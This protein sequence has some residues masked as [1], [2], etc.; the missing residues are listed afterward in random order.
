LPSLVVCRLL[1]GAT[2]LRESARTECSRPKMPAH[3]MVEAEALRGRAEMAEWR[4][5]GA[6]GASE[7]RLEWAGLVAEAIATRM[8]A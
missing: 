6:V 1:M 8:I 5:L 7:G 3:R 2:R 4:E